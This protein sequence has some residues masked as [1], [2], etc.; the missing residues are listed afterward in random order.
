METNPRPAPNPNLA[1]DRSLV[2]HTRAGAT[3]FPAG[4]SA[5]AGLLS[6]MADAVGVEPTRSGFSAASQGSS[7]IST[8]LR[9]SKMADVDGVETLPITAPRVFEARY[10]PTRWQH[11]KVVVADGAGF[12]PAHRFP[13]GL[14]LA[15]RH[16]AA[17]STVHIRG[18]RSRLGASDRLLKGQM[19]LTRVSYAR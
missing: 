8:P 3:R 1:D 12:E 7:L 6:K 11:P 13:R 15:N 5:L 9:A 10:R 19:L 2:D 17:L 4:S 14:G 16:I 18:P